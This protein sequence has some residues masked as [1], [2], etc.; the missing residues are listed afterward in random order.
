MWEKF[1]SLFVSPPGNAKNFPFA[2]VNLCRT[3]YIT[4]ETVDLV[5]KNEYEK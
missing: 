3:W 4:N 2:V 5:W 1:G